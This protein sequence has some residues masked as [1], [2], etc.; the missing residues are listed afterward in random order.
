METI[1]ENVGQNE[2]PNPAV[3]FLASAFVG[4]I[5]GPR[6]LAVGRELLESKSHEIAALAVDRFMEVLK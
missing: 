6:L 3:I 4:L 2:L 1:V 5:A